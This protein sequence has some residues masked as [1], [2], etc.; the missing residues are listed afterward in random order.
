M[1]RNPLP[2]E[3]GTPGG[4]HVVGVRMGEDDAVQ[5]TFTVSAFAQSASYCPGAKSGIEQKPVNALVMSTQKQGG[6][7]TAGRA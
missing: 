2:F 5:A 6:V 4:A 1:N 7:A 3:R